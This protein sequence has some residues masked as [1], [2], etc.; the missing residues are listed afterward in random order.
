[1]NDHAYRLLNAIQKGDYWPLGVRNR[2]LRWMGVEVGIG[3]IVMSGCDFIKGPISL[4]R[5][6]FVNQRC[7][8]E[9]AGGITIG[10][11]VRIGHGTML[12]TSTHEEGS[13]IRRAGPLVR[14]PI[15]IGDGAWIGAACTIIPGSIIGA[16]SIVGATSL[17]RGRLNED[18][19][20][21]GSPA[22]PYKTLQ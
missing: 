21:V 17:V 19:A 11:E 18:T 8:I 7:L 22:K 20:N 15:T 6:A 12:L 3:S 10:N 5:N 9:G 2:I 13:R 16:R 14:L 4:G 1:M